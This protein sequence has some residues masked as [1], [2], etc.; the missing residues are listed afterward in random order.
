MLTE[1]GAPI[2]SLV[3]PSIATMGFLR[4]QLMMISMISGFIH[5]FLY[6]HIDTAGRSRIV[7]IISGVNH[8]KLS[9]FGL[10]ARP[11]EPSPKLVQVLALPKQPDGTKPE[12]VRTVSVTIPVL[13]SI[14]DKVLS[15]KFV[16]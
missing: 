5:I 2:I 9:L 8:I 14:T 7:Q 13:P 12:P 16:E 4:I 10:T 15:A 11:D 1:I 3:C 6:Q